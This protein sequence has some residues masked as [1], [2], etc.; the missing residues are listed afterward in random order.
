M[1]IK[2]LGGSTKIL[3][4]IISRVGRVVLG[5]DPSGNVG[6]MHYLFRSLYSAFIVIEHLP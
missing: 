2:S 5:C 1:L 6:K 3:N 4:F